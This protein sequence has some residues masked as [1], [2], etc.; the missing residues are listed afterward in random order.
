MNPLPQI[1]AHKV[2]FIA[3]LC[4]AYKKTVSCPKYSDSN[5]KG[6]YTQLM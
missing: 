5:L 1:H 6:N 3:E 2:G 4:P